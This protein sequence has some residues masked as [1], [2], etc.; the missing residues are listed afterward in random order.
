MING[1]DIEVEDCEV[2]GLQSGHHSQQLLR[3]PSRPYFQVGMALHHGHFNV[4]NDRLVSTHSIRH[5]HRVI[6]HSWACWVLWKSEEFR[7]GCGTSSL[8]IFLLFL[9]TEPLQALLKLLDKVDRTSYDRRLITLDHSISNTSLRKIPEKIYIYT[10]ELKEK[11]QIPFEHRI[12]ASMS[13]GRRDTHSSACGGCARLQCESFSGFRFL[14]GSFCSWIGVSWGE[15][16]MMWR[17][18]EWNQIP[19]L[20]LGLGL[21]GMNCDGA[22]RSSEALLK[23]EEVEKENSNSHN[24]GLFLFGSQECQSSNFSHPP[25]Q[26]QIHSSSSPQTSCKDL[27]HYNQTGLVERPQLQV[28]FF[29]LSISR[30]WWELCF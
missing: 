13:G 12:Q 26:G 1:C 29:F 9:T 23:E 7:E 30:S 14:L 25:F 28:P 5:G 2:Q 20:V 11:R 4:S 3:P 22:T 17:S 15:R 10:Q 27:C 8:A 19:E 18:E 6:T 24:D 16:K 21:L